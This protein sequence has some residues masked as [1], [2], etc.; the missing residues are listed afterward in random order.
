LALLRLDRGA[1]F[2]EIDQIVYDIRQGFVNAMDD[3][4]NFPVALAAFF[5]CIRKINTLVRG[6]ALSPDDAAKILAAFKSVDEVMQIFDFPPDEIAADIRSL[7]A[8]R[9]EARKSGDFQRAD[10][11]RDLLRG[12]GVAIHDNRITTQ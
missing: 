4:L 12:R 11:I 10:R 5:R 9:E 6:E 7:I 1:P 2:P 8:E 3:D